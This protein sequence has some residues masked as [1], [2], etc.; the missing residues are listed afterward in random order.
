MDR[1]TS[2]TPRTSDAETSANVAKNGDEQL[3]FV[4]DLQMLG[5]DR[6]MQLPQLVVVGDQNTGKSSVLQ[7]ITKLPFP[8]NESMCTRFPTEVVFRRSVTGAKTIVR[9]SI[10]LGKVRR[11]DTALKERV[12]EFSFT[13]DELTPQVM[14]KI[15]DEAYYSCLSLINIKATQS[16]FGVD[17]IGKDSRWDTGLSDATLRIER[18]GPNE[19]HWSIVDLPGLIQGK[20]YINMLQENGSS[21]GT[22]DSGPQKLPSRSPSPESSTSDITVAEDLVRTYLKNERSIVLAV[23]DPA[24]YQR[25]RIFSLIEH[26]PRLNKRLIGIITKCD[27]K[28]EGSDTWIT[29]LLNNKPQTSFCP[30]KHGRFALRNRKPKEINVTNDERDSLE[31][32]EFSKPDWE[33]VP[34]D[35][36]GIHSLMT[37]INAERKNQIRTSM[38]ALIEEI[39]TR[40]QKCLDEL[41]AMGGERD[42]T[43]SQRLYLWKVANHFQ[44]LSDEALSGRSEDAVF[45]KDNTKL[46]LVVQDRLETFAQQISDPN[47]I[48]IPFES[49]ILSPRRSASSSVYAAQLGQSD[50][51][52][53]ILQ[54]AKSHRG[55]DLPGDINCGVKRHLFRRQS[56]H[57]GHMAF[58]LFEEVREMVGLCTD[59]LLYEVCPDAKLISRVRRFLNNAM[60]HWIA[61]ARRELTELIEENQKRLLF[62][63][64]PLYFSS[65]NRGM[66]PDPREDAFDGDSD[67]FSVHTN[68][69]LTPNSNHKTPTKHTDSAKSGIE[70]MLTSRTGYQVQS[71]HQIHDSLYSY[72]NIALW[73]FVDNVAMQVVERHLLGHKS[74]IRMLTPEFVGKLSDVELEE[75]A[76]EDTETTERRKDLRETEAMFKKA[77]LSWEEIR[78]L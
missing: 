13:C 32:E 40:Q 64:N 19:M 24:D 51:Y 38:P 61:E 60:I 7:A 22:L 34:K 33:D 72:Y 67:L 37:F 35:R 25:H 15:M 27:M 9:T 62:T 71:V 49:H 57:W 17:A 56:A 10:R 74:P 47:A 73:R 28:Q 14:E 54:E 75:L 23:I 77:L 30:L 58:Q 41:N 53:W 46:R 65:S 55:T 2:T 31:R 66:Q 16:I 21:Y 1:F 18:S 8:V 39:E 26:I 63:L 20:K 69:R 48:P 78:S 59:V 70:D 68:G 42:N 11:K 44:Q 5:L 52:S 29:N 6:C 4:D 3:E 36:I 12:K 43:Q 45:D 76:G 50:I